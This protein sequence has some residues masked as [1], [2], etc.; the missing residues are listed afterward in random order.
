MVSRRL[1]RR[2]LLA[3]T[4]VGIAS[5]AAAGPTP[6][7]IMTQNMDEGTNYQALATATDT[8]SF[9]AAV[10]QTYQEIAAT[11]PDIRAGAIAREIAAQHPTLVALQE[12][13]IVRSGPLG[14]PA[15]T[16]NSNLLSSLLTG[17]GSLGQHYA[18]VI[19]GTEL[20]A[21]APS[22]R[23]LNV[24]L[25]TQD[26]ILA[27]TD[28]QASQFSVGNAQA[29]HFSV[30]LPVPTPV[31]P[32]ELTRGWVSADVTVDGRKFRL[33]TTHLD[34]GQFGPGIQF[35]Q[36]Q[37]LLSVG[38]TLPVIYAGDFNSAAN[39]PRDPTFPTYQ[40]LIGSGLGDA[41]TTLHPGDPGLT[42]C[43]AQDLLNPN[44]TLTQ[45]I[46]LALFSAGFRVLDAD[47]VGVSP[48][49]KTATGLWP[50]DHA[51]LVASFALAPEPA[52]IGLFGASLGVLG[53]LGRRRRT[54]APAVVVAAAALLLARPAAS[55]PALYTFGD[56]LSDAGNVFLAT[57]GAEPAPP[58]SA[59][60]YSNGPVWVQDLAS[61]FGLPAL[62]PSGAGGNDY[63]VGGAHTGATPV[64]PVVN[65]GDLPTQ[66]AMFAA[67]HPVAPGGALYTIG[68]GATDLG[69]LLT[70]GNPLGLAPATLAAAITN[71]DT[72]VGSLAASGARH[73]MVMTVPDLGV[74]PA[75]TM[76]GPAASQ[77]ASGLT[78]Q[79]N[80]GL[81]AS[82]MAIAA[83]DGLD[84]RFLD[85][86]A[87]L[88]RAVQHPAAFGFTDVTTP[89][90]TGDFFGN[91]GSL[92]ATTAAGQDA[93]LFWDIEHPT[94]AGHAMIADA[95]LRLVPEP[96]SLTLLAL[97]LSGL[98]VVL[99][100]RRAPSIIPGTRTG[101]R[102]AG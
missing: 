26:V 32:V 34:T 64:S 59:G 1:L 67:S 60:R 42:C 23:G 24:R 27:R 46:D 66:Y 54:G 52:S 87:L 80:A 79:F 56:S 3:A 40:A 17:L 65:P 43:E 36:A 29:G 89:C 16:V 62:T 69:S 18:P 93:H 70:S 14:G 11:T 9:L 57:G 91:G 10:T 86:F 75:V 20:D 92:C 2:W 102:C 84:I 49:D 30:Q 25:T 7:T 6:I 38:G 8:A 73:F 15:T 47:L 99:R 78:A 81:E 94:E 71:V 19:V 74:A 5:A 13:S 68:I 37:E 44:P 63:A 100:K 85:A 28:L 58:Y 21:T 4:G 51:G 39:D 33:V 90:W 53:M 88:D 31:G 50:S 95:A 48:A 82:L 97:S 45:R 96:A 12:A 72:V 101:M 83:A 41:W 55:F 61:R 77:L 35:A 98:G 76:F 22:S